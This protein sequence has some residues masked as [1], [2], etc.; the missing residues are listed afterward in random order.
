MLWTNVS[1]WPN[2]GLLQ[3]RHLYQFEVQSRHWAA[4]AMRFSRGVAG[5]HGAREKETSDAVGRWEPIRDWSLASLNEKLNKIG[6]KV[7]S[8]GR[9][10]ALQMAKVGIPRH[11][12]EEILRL[13]AE[14][15]PTPPHAPA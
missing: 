13:T 10:I 5:V 3:R 4:D 11:M 14:L 15:R 1:H 7:I 2:S 9:T 12:F 6:T 8:H